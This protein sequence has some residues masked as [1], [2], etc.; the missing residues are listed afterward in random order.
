MHPADGRPAG[1]V[2]MG[3][4][5]DARDGS[6]LLL[7]VNPRIGSSFRLF[8]DEDGGDVVR[9]LYLDLTDQPISTSSVHEGR[10]WLVENQDL[11]TTWKLLRRRQLSVIQWFQSLRGVEELAW[12]SRDDLR[13]VALML[14]GTARQAVG[15]LARRLFRRS[16]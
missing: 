3:F 10:R 13:P 5:H 6:Y 8:V 9:A 4:R 14:L 1:I 16:G 15:A 11:A 2:D 12:W 7:D